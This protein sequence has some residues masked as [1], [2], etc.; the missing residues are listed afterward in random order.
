MFSTI[1]VKLEVKSGQSIRFRPEHNAPSQAHAPPRAHALH[2]S[3]PT[4]TETTRRRASPAA[5]LP[6]AAAI[7]RRTLLHDDA[8]ASFHALP[9]RLSRRG[10]LPCGAVRRS[11]VR[12]GSLTMMRRRTLPEHYCRALLPPRHEHDAQ[13][14]ERSARTPIARRTRTTSINRKFF[15]RST[16][17]G[18]RAACRADHLKFV[19]DIMLYAHH[20]A[21]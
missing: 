20:N 8:K 2:H 6:A 5:S 19:S 1:A 15:I 12:T 13:I 17:N 18:R 16:T 10:Q 4:A 14:N 9:A 3:R 7:L 21:A 11:A